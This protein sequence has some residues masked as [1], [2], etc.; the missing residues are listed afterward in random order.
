MPNVGSLGDLVA[1]RDGL[2]HIAGSYLLDPETG[3]YTLPYVDRVFGAASPD[4][5]MVRL[6]ER[7][8]G[9]IV[10][11]GNP[12]G[13]EGL[14]DVGRRRTVRPGRRAGRDGVTATRSAVVAAPV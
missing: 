2:C 8:Q 7:S 13:I 10:A 6:A 5:A 14:A 9:L 3:E 12:L 1:L 4:V 11:A